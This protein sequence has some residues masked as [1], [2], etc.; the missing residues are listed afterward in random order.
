LNIISEKATI[1]SIALYDM[2]GK[3]IIAEKPGDNNYKLD[4]S[5]ISEGTYVIRIASGKK[6]ITK[7]IQIVE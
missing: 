3:K 5:D 2:N 1:N 7:K 4:L 6:M